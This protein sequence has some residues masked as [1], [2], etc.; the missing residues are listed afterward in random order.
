M[1]RPTLV[2]VGCRHSMRL[3][4]SLHP[5][6]PVRVAS[7]WRLGLR[8]GQPLRPWS[9]MDRRAPSPPPHPILSSRRL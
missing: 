3:I 8:P 4:T 9:S 6:R 5:L 1:R 7:H 2:R